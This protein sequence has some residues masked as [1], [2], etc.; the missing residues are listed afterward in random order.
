MVVEAAE[1]RQRALRKA[2]EPLPARQLAQAQL[3]FDCRKQ[4]PK[5]CK[6]SGYDLEPW[7][8]AE[9]KYLNNLSSRPCR[10]EK[11]G[12]S[13]MADYLHHSQLLQHALDGRGLRR[14][15]LAPM[16]TKMQDLQIISPHE[17][18]SESSPRVTAAP[19]TKS[20]ALKM[21]M[22][23][24]TE[25]SSSSTMHQ[26]CPLPARDRDELSHCLSS[27][28]ILKIDAPLILPGMKAI[29]PKGAMDAISKIVGKEEELSRHVGQRAS[30]PR[31]LASIGQHRR[32]SRWHHISPFMQYLKRN[33]Q[34]LSDA[35]V[36]EEHREGQM[37]QSES[38]FSYGDA[39]HAPG[40]EVHAKTVGMVDS[41]HSWIGKGQSGQSAP[42][43][44]SVRVAA[45]TDGDKAEWR[46]NVALSKKYR[47]SVNEIRDIKREFQEYDLDGKGEISKDQFHAIIRKRGNLEER[48]EIPQHLLIGIAPDSKLVN[49]E[50]FLIWATMTAWSEE[51]IM[52]DL[53]ERRIRKL[54]R[55]QE[56]SLSDVERVKCLFDK[57][58]VDGSGEIE[59]GEFRILLYDL[60]QCRKDDIPV[61]RLQRYWREVDLDG[62]GSVGFNEFLIWYKTSFSQD[63]KFK[64]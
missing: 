14:D 61:K 13:L 58:D 15:K 7:E 50:S 27:K 11:F 53:N 20:S 1:M 59:Q 8:I 37:F 56:M 34:F 57:I 10:S 18:E 52:P 44:K 32:E 64:F 49:F 48:E 62:S 25:R 2:L 12:A 43:K 42:V 21:A 16:E 6:Q 46:S 3:A 39:D 47:V 60:L 35:L 51:F 38:G 63:G 30:P 22:A 24:E 54:A 4:K 45:E 28:H 5:R 55:E 23:M 9:L 31:S 36:D 19:K 26:P 41:L 33:R 40:T 17:V 29:R